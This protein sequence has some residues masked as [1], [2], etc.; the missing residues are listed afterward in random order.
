MNTG[1]VDVMSL[2]EDEEIMA[3]YVE[4]KAA[5]LEETRGRNGIAS[6]D[7]GIV[8]GSYSTSYLSYY[9]VN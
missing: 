7:M 9:G 3:K 4:L 2:R 5:I 1:S 8:V 6:E